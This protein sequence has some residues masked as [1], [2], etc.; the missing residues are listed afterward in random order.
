MGAVI[1]LLQFIINFHQ[2]TQETVYSNM[3]SSADNFA[4]ITLQNSLQL[5][6]VAKH[7]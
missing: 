5:S 1:F 6:M 7:E 4:A 2:I 3:I